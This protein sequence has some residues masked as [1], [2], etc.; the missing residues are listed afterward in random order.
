M[1]AKFLNIT[2]KT[3]VGELLEAYPALETVLIEISTV[4]AKLK[5]PVLRKTIARVA[6]LQQAAIIGGMPVEELVNRLR[7]EAGQETLSG[8]VEVADYLSSEPPAW[9]SAGKISDRFDATQMINVG[10]S[11]MNEVLH[12]A[13][14]LTPGQILELTAPF[15]PAPIIEMLQNKGFAC[16]TRKTGTLTNTFIYRIQTRQ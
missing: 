11:P 2:P 6:T 10:D 12:R 4:F 1:T 16:W 7:Q 5:N 3:K 8:S 14:S 9:Y 15:L 13:K